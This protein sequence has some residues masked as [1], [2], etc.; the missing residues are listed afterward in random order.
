MACG[1]QKVDHVTNCNYY[2][3]PSV[4]PLREGLVKLYKGILS[5]L[6]TLCDER[7]VT[8]CEWASSFLVSGAWYVGE[9]HIND[10]EGY[11]KYK[12]KSEFFLKI[13]ITYVANFSFA[14]LLLSIL[15]FL[16]RSINPE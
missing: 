7:M 15:F 13:V 5:R 6:L 12:P 8:F 11:M 10:R 1:L 4:A 14:I 3:R 9:K 16:E 2:K